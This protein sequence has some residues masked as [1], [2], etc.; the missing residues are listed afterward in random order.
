MYDAVI[1][2]EATMPKTQLKT[3]RFVLYSKNTEVVQVSIIAPE[4]PHYYCS[5]VYV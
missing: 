2:W 4:L 1:N 3:F 5:Q